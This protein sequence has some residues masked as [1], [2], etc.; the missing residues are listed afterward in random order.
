MDDARVRFNAVLAGKGREAQYLIRHE[1]IKRLRAR[2]RE[3][4]IA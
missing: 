2:F 1:F 3:E 4:H